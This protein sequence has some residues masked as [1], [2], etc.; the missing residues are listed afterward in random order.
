MRPTNLYGDAQHLPYSRAIPHHPSDSTRA[1]LP[2]L[3][4]GVGW[5]W[6]FHSNVAFLLTLPKEGVA[7]ERMYGLA[8]AWIHPYQARVSA[9]DDGA[10]ELIL[11]TSARPNWPYTSVWFNG[12]THHMPLPKEG[13]LSAMME[14]MLSNIPCRRI[15]HLEVH[16][17]LHSEAWV[18]YP[19]GLNGCLVPVTTTLPNHY[20]MAWPCFDDEPT[21][22][23]VD[24]LQFMMEGCESNSSFL[25][26][27]STATY[28]TC[29]AMV[30]PPKL[31]SQVSMTMEVIELS[32]AA[33]DTSGEAFGC[34]TPQRPVSQARGAPPHLMLENTTK[35]VDTSSQVS[36]L[37]S[38]PDN[39][40][41]DN[42]TLEEISLPVETLE[43]GAGILPVDVIQ[44][45]EEA[46]KA[47]GCLLMTRSSSGACWRKEVLDFEMALCQNKSETT[48]AIKEAK[49]LCT[50]TIREAEAHHAMLIN[51]AETQHATWMKEAEANCASIV[52]EAENCLSTTIRK[53]ESHSTKQA[54]S[55][56]QSHAKGI[57]H[58]ETDAIEEEGKDC[59]SFLTIC[60]AALQASP[61]KTMGFWWP[62]FHL[63]LENMPLS[64][65][66]NIHPPVSSTWH[67]SAPLAPHPTAPVAPGLFAPSKWWHPSPSQIVS[68][69]QSEAT[70]HED[71]G[72]NTSSQSINRESAGSL[73]QGFRSS[74]EGKRGTLQ[75]KLPTFQLQEL[76]QPDEH[77][78]GHDHI[79][80]ST[81]FPNLWDPGVLGRAEQAAICYDALRASP[82]GLQFFHAIS[83]SELPKVMSLAGIHNPEA[84]HYFNGMTFC[85]WCGKEGQNKGTI[86]NH[87]QMTHYKL[88]LVCGTCFHCPSV[89]SEAIQCHGWKSC[90]HPQGEDGA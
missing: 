3:L 59:L 30:P 11:L 64:T 73:H 40:E 38:I 77:F 12:D 31:G 33:V 37:V 24:I 36:P 82:K 89:T 20:P 28:P 6:R 69:P 19:K 5:P 55:I 16:Q 45:Q 21:L 22:L 13:H 48:E 18:V 63:L 52:A 34:S 10:S 87:L 42:P 4:T 39:A 72:W 1:L 90:Q 71:K 7:G 58:L 74:M 57:Q 27:A 86:V 60:S 29:S 80:Q 67:K 35:P 62:P 76:M 54:C 17:L 26:G 23:Q 41:L 53:A 25:S 88:G 32:W 49:T 56:Q 78:L 15:C 83:P 65:L 84:L 79:H 44:L 14:G 66:L 70:P 75:D 50:C 68:P 9:I 8:M 85:P 51:K 61:P 2:H 47:L 46:G 43:L 81:R